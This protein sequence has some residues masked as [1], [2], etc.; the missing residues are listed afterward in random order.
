MEFY[1]VDKGEYPILKTALIFADSVSDGIKQAKE[2][3]ENL[4]QKNIYFQI[5]EEVEE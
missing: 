4:N 3:K 2:I 5:E 1:K